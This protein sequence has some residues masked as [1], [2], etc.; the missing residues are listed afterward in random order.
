MGRID[1]VLYFENS[2]CQSPSKV[3]FGRQDSKST[4]INRTLFSAGFTSQP[5]VKCTL[6]ALHTLF[7]A[8]YLN[9]RE[10]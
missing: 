6:T 2:L 5:S 8:V 4:E 10:N 3:D 7:N 9:E 1:L